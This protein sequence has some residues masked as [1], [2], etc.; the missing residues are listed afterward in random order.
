[1]YKVYFF[2]G[3]STFKVLI[4]D[5]VWWKYHINIFL[6]YISLIELHLIICDF[7]L[8]DKKLKKHKKKPKEGTRQNNTILFIALKLVNK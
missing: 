4:S 6:C 2:F 3:E 8:R 7:H 1:M 5:F